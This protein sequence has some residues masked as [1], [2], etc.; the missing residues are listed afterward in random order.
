MTAVLHPLPTELLGSVGLLSVPSVSSPKVLHVINGQHYS[1]AERVQDLLAG[2]LPQFGFDCGFAC[3]RPDRFVERRVSRDVPL[4][5]TPMQSRI[6]TRMVGRLASLVERHDY[7][8][9][10]AHTPR[11]AWIGSLVAR[12]TGRPLIYHVHS[13][14]VREST[15]RLLNH[16]RR[17]VERWS[18]RRASRLI[19]VSESL[20]RQMCAS[21][22][23]RQ[24]VACVPNGVPVVGPLAKRRLPTGRWTIG[25]VALF[26]PR[27]GL[28]VLLE[29]VAD[30]RREG[31]DLGV[32]AIGEFETP[33]YRRQI[34]RLV[35]SLGLTGVVEWT[36]FTSDVTAALSQLDLFVLPSLFGEGLPMVVLEAMAAGVPVVASRVEGVPE[37]IRD[38]IDGLLVAPGDRQ[39]LAEAL[40]RVVGGQVSW[41]ALRRAAHARQRE[42]FSDESMARGV[43]TVYR[44]VLAVGAHPVE[45]MAI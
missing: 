5:I 3:V 38:E 11:T 10:H 27:K 7:R 2:R 9:I 22:F 24:R 15:H 6:D 17:H 42:H 1:G 16:L 21:G 33:E 19:A 44:E 32:R 26:R 31:L 30:L 37:A 23:A 25:T 35:Q 14:A 45:R 34:V 8:L 28:E 12:A 43:A 39:A 29:A 13:P 36:G 40:A 20:R 18:L 4:Y 41:H